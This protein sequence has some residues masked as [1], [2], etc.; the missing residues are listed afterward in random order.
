MMNEVLGMSPS[1]TVQR[2]TEDW[3]RRSMEAQGT[4]KAEA[5]ALVSPPPACDI[6]TV[7]PPPHRAKQTRLK[8]AVIKTLT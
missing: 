2:N 3:K 8:E 7:R 6:Y 4:G 1:P 5:G